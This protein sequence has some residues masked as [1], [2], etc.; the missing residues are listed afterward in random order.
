MWQ[1]I[2]WPSPRFGFTP[3]E[4]AKLLPMVDVDGWCPSQSPLRVSRPD[5]ENRKVLPSCTVLS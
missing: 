2:D 1:R 3:A 5:V 4:T